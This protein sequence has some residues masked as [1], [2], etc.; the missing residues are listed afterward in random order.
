MNVNIKPFE[1]QSTNL[2][3][4]NN[5]IV[6]DCQMVFD[7]YYSL[8][9][10]LPSL[11]ILGA[12]RHRFT[13]RIFPRPIIFNMFFTSFD[14]LEYSIQNNP[15]N[16][17]PTLLL[18]IDLATEGTKFYSSSNDSELTSY[19]LEEFTMAIHS[20]ERT[21]LVYDTRCKSIRCY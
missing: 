5:S 3:A 2:P 4:I 11:K 17:L 10:R 7:I 8:S 6:R 20:N 15:V 13:S 18:R 14:N 21:S 19:T 12:S 1:D 16:L 9:M